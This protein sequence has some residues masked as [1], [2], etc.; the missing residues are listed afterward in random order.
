M[1]TSIASSVRTP[2][3]RRGRATRSVSRK[4]WSTLSS[5]LST[6]QTSRLRMSISSLKS[7][8]THITIS[9]LHFR[10]I[11]PQA[12]HPLFN[13]VCCGRGLV[14]LH[15]SSEVSWTPGLSSLFHN[16]ICNSLTT[17]LYSIYHHFHLS[18]SP[19]PINWAG[20][21][22][23]NIPCISKREPLFEFG[24]GFSFCCLLK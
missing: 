18:L 16:C 13:V 12:L 15:C 24:V 8:I 1:G 9:H 14:C 20:Q 22:E 3:P 6:T 10:S 2:T 21:A 19:G 7:A 11:F 23:S 4:L 5:M 17:F